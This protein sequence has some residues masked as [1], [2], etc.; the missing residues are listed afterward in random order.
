MTTTKVRRANAK[1]REGAPDYVVDCFDH[2]QYVDRY[3]VIVV[4]EDGT[5]MHLSS[6]EGMGFSGWSDISRHA[7]AAWR[8]RSGRN[9]IRWSDV[10][11]RIRQAV[12]E[13]MTPA[14]TEEDK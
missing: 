10:P 4:H 5:L 3:T 9:R 8:G 1:W 11:E 12:I 13:D 14:T 7:A 2:P 6:S